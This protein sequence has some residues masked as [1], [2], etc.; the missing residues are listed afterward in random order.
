[1][2]SGTCR[3]RV[4]CAAASAGDETAFVTSFLRSPAS[5]ALHFQD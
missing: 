2:G 5:F 1:L 4:G 3:L